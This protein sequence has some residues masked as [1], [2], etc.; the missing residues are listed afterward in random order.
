MRFPRSVLVVLGGLFWAC[1]PVAGICAQ[2]DD[3][4]GTLAQSLRLEGVGYRLATANAAA[5]PAPVMRTG[6]VLHDLAAYPRDRRARIGRDRDL[7]YG[8][9]V[10][11][12][13]PGSAGER[14][15][16]RARDEIL[17]L[18]GMTLAD[19][20]TARFGKAATFARTG[21]FIDF[22]ARAL[23]RGTASLQVRRGQEVL[24]LSL[25]G[26]PGC[27]GYVAAIRSGALN[28]WSDGT[29]VAVTTRLIDY[30]A[31]D[32]Q[33]GFVVAHEMAHNLLGHN[34]DRQTASSL[35]ALVGVGS[36]TLRDREIAA[37]RYGVQLMAQAGYDRAGAIA[38]LAQLDR[39]L[40][41]KLAIDFSHPGTG[42]RITLI[43]A[44]IAGKAP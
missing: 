29:A 37:D 4:Q 8:F 7:T 31:D 9:G 6:L 42:R 34:E 19:Y 5:C 25:D 22:L 21:A 30:A 32:A 44:A 17:A 40:L 18:N 27:G 26:V 12:V 41:M 39:N 13:V 28:A 36:G 20:E 43:K 10:L 14:A 23:G 35:L 33:L 15:G 11:G 24:A 1:T 38:L 2:A 3:D 16:L